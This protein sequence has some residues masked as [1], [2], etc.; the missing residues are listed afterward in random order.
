VAAR[1]QWDDFVLDLDSYRLERSGIPLSLEPKAF[2]LL[3]LMVQR[4]GHL[5]TKQEIFEALWADTAVTDHALT[6]V[7][8]Q[9]RRVLGDEAR[10]ARYVETV[11][12][13]G[14]RWIAVIQQAPDAMAPIAPVAPAPF[15]RA[16]GFAAA[17]ALGMLALLFLAWAQGRRPAAADDLRVV[18]RDP[19]WP[20]Q[21]TTHAGLDMHPAMSPQGDAIAFVSNRSGAF[22]IYVRGLSGGARE[23]PLTSDGA[24]NMQPAWSPDGRFIAYHA[25]NRG[26]IWVVPARGGTPRQVSATGARPAW[27]PDGTR[28][29]YQTD[30]FGDIA[31]NGYSAQAGST[32]WTVDADGTNARA[33]TSTHP[34]THSPRGGG[35]GPRPGGGHAA[36]AWSH[37]G[38]FLAFTVFD[39]GEDNG[40]W[41]LSV[42]TGETWPL[43]LR[44][45]MYDPVFLKDDAAV[46]AGGAE[47][48]IV[49]MPIDPRTGKLNA[50][51]EVIPL[52]GVPGVRGLSLSPDGRRLAF[53][54]MSLDSQ[55]WSLELKPDGSPAG[56]PSQLTR[57]T[58]RR[59][60]LA[61]ISPDGGKI[62]YMSMRQGE[63][64][65]VWLMN[66]DG[67][68]PIQ[69]TSD[70]SAE[71]KP[72][73]F[74]DSV[75]VGYLTKR[76]RT[77]GLYSVD[78]N[79]RREQL[80]FGF[81]GAEKYPG[82]DGTL[83][84]FEASPSMTQIALSM[85]TP[86]GGERRLYV[87]AIDDFRP[88]RIGPPGAGYPAWSPDEKHLAVEIKD[89]ISTHAA[90]IDVATGAMKQL[91]KERGHTWVRSWSPDGRKV[92]VAAMRDNRWNVR[93][94][95][96]A[97]A[98]EGALTPPYAAGVYV[99]YPEWSPKGDRVLFERGVSRGNIWTI[100]ID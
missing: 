73:W 54:G 71:H 28:I 91:T 11:P 57:D 100:A 66:I 47:A 29:A 6:R 89:G 78:I 65:N 45:S 74:P 16:P 68:N 22:E 23:V 8:A 36:P 34:T 46:A 98:K 26:G 20:V 79:T 38:R 40:V 76:R 4:P 13:R 87:S 95:E 17:L 83:A 53:S 50:P 30:E 37:S 77:G 31:P 21:L 35:P 94:I 52:A 64:P 62:A 48:L 70:D 92:A 60:A 96:V 99:R 9:L 81:A 32:I 15:V 41:M 63:L 5:F 90:V 59:N 7:V 43:E 56:E 69:L 61:V 19:R 3:V 67:S 84:E 51:P 93:W 75:R 33:L 2:N 14:Y 49:R 85:L 55:I 18:S 10:E 39:G 88:R 12:T 27:S 72:A 58:S 82:L 24:E 86:P 42:E 97:T 25:N 1:Y 80:V 44:T